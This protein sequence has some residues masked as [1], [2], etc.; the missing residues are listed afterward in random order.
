MEEK[1]FDK[2]LSLELFITIVLLIFSLF[3]LSSV[4]NPEC[5]SDT[6]TLFSLIIGMFCRYGIFGVIIILLTLFIFLHLLIKYVN[7]ESKR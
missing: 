1:L 7:K 3:I 4:D 6:G 5:S 2:Y